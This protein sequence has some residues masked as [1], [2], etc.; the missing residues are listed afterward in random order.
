VKARIINLTPHPVTVVSQDGGTAHVF[1]PS[2]T[3]PRCREDVVII[4]DLD[5]IPLVRKSLGQVENL[6]DPQEGV[7]YIVSLAV[8][9]AARRP[10]LLV[11]DDMVRDEQG[12]ILGCRRFA[13]VV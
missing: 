3:V 8:A 6:P 9:Q 13:V 4:G 7:Y 10:D 5:G 11:P 12:R 1:M 2:G